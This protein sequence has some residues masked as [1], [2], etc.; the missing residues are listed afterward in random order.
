M[1]R[2]LLLLLPLVCLTATASQAQT[3][4]TLTYSLTESGTTTVI[5][6]PAEYSDYTFGITGFSNVGA[7]PAGLY[8]IFSLSNSTIENS[9]N[10]YSVTAYDLPAGW[11]FSDSNDFT[12]STSLARGIH[13]TD[14][15]FGLTIT[16]KAGTP[17]INISN[18]PFTL[19]HKVDGV[20]PFLNPN[21]TPMT[22]QA[23]PEASSMVSFSLLMVSGLVW[24]VCRR[25]RRASKAAV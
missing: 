25:T 13:A 21:G 11:T 20:D 4:P 24:H 9:P 6:L 17:F 23:V 12:I 18:A 19:Y 22:V 7:D 10:F 3:P 8:T 5:G 2:H 1:N 16:Q 15:S 14:P